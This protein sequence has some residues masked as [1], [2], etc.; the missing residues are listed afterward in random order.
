M[1]LTRNPLFTLVVNTGTAKSYQREHSS[2]EQVHF[3]KICKVMK[4]LRTDQSVVCMVIHDLDIHSVQQFVIRLRCCSFEPGICIPV[5]S[6][7]VDDITA[8][9]VLFHHLF[10]CMDI[11]LTVTINGYRDIT[12]IH[13]FHQP[14]Q[15]SI[16]MPPVPALRNPDVMPVL[17]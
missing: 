16:L 17:L 14:R 6:D 9:M 3:M 12:M 5:I 10:H 11:I 7:S 15:D 13:R 8:F 4:D 1:T 2:Q